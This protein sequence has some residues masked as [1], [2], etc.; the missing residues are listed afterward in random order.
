ML[1]DTLFL[2]AQIYN[3]FLKQWN[4][5]DVAVLKGKILYVGKSADVDI[6][7][8]TT[9]D[10]KN[11]P[12]IPGL[13]DIHLHIESSLCTPSVFANAVLPHG[14]TTV[15]AEPHE[16]ANVFGLSGIEEMIRVSEGS[17]IDIFYGVPS[18]VP[19]TNKKLETSGGTI[20]LKELEELVKKYPEIICLGEVMNYSSLIGDFSKIVTEEKDCKTL[21]LINYMKKQAPLAAIEGHC[22]S[23]RDLELAKLLYLGID[24]DHCLQD[25]EGM[26]QRFANGMFVELQDKSITPEIVNYLQSYD[27]EG[28]FCFVTDD[29]PPDI[30]EEKGHLDYIVRKA[31]KNGLSLEKAIIATSLAPAKRMGFRDR[32]IIAPGKIA[33]FI[34]LEDVSNEFKIQSVYKGGVLFNLKKVDKTIH[35]FDPGFLDSLNLS[36]SSIS[37]EMYI[38]KVNPGSEGKTTV[39]CRI[40]RKNSKNTYTES[41]FRSLPVSK[42]VINWSNPE[43]DVNLAIVIDRYS[44]EAHTAQGLIDGVRLHNGAFCTSHAHDHHNILL[45]GDNIKDMKEA[46]S[47]VIN[48]KGG[49]CAISSTKILASVPLPVGGI[50]SEAPMEKLS[51]D[52]SSLQQALKKLGIDHVNPIMSMCTLTLPVSPELKITDR[53]LIDVKASKVVSLFAE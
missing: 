43:L 42:G 10:C 2:N 39:K 19:S 49:M 32:G 3:V 7:A 8:S 36:L 23:V 13:I 51:K 30:M 21:K 28:L 1:V 38:L 33:D 9:I 35:K 18:S 47:W 4:I 25:I 15:V 52:V 26:R 45:V 14:V 53:G 5:N 16:I 17:V 50:L 27:V 6:T 24:S 48:N 31:L 44:G 34:L 40:M 11:K 20:D 29:V 22:P 37:D 41:V 46:L 12:L